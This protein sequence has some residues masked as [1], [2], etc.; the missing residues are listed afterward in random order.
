MRYKVFSYMKDGL[1]RKMEAKLCNELNAMMT[2]FWWGS[3]GQEK[4]IHWLSWDKLSD[5]KPDGGMGFKDLRCYNLE[6]LAKQGWR[7]MN[8]DKAMINS[9]K[10]KQILWSRVAGIRGQNVRYR[11]FDLISLS[12]SFDSCY[13]IYIF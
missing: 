3:K 5:K 9:G 2:K 8:V 13:D 6:M 1:R 11:N 7:L 10:L 4:K 12:H